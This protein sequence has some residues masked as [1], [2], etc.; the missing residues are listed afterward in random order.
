MPKLTVE[1]HAP[2]DVEEG[3][4]LTYGQVGRKGFE[5]KRTEVESLLSRKRPEYIL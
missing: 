1:G 4:R 5:A 2:V 3:K